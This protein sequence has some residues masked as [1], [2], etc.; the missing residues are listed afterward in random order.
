MGRFKPP[1]EKVLAA[2]ILTLLAAALAYEAWRTGVT[3]DEPAHLI[4][5]Y[6]Y[7]HG[8]DDL[9]PGDL[10]PLIKMVGGWVPRLIGLPLPAD[11][12]GPGETRH[13]WNVA[14]WMMERLPDAQRVF[15]WSRL[16]L[17]IFPLGTVLLV[18]RWGRQLFGPGPG[19]LLMLA[20]APPAGGR[21]SPI[22]LRVNGEA[23]GADTQFRL[24]SHAASDVAR[25][26]R[27]QTITLAD[28]RGR[29]RVILDFD[30]Y[31]GHP[32]LR[33]RVRYRNLTSRRV[34]VEGADM[35]QIGRASCRE[36]V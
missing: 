23:I 21:T 13:E 11:L 15:F 3:V 34:T 26:G 7:W 18:W 16:P 8:K 28:V 4:S 36:R 1:A 25:S 6:L 9:P 33:Y 14:L 32:V 29:G 30:L 20:C 5:S 10:P 19:L 12:G 27:R 31:Q 35:L 22:R 2:G 17:L 24:V